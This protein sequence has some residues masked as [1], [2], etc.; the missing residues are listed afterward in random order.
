M[1]TKVLDAVKPGVLFG[2]YVAKVQLHDEVEFNVNFEV[3]AD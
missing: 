2:D 1:S 3:F